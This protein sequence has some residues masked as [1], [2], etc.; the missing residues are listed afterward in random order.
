PLTIVFKDD[1]AEGVENPQA[2]VLLGTTQKGFVQILVVNVAAL[3]ENGTNFDTVFYHEMTH[4]VLND[5]VG[6]EASQRI[7][8]WVQE[9]LAVYICGEGD[10]R[11]HE[12]AQH[13]RRSEVD[14]LVRDVEGPY[15]GLAY[16]QYYLAIKYMVDTAS[17]NAPQALVRNLIQGRT[18]SEAIY[19]S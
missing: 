10:Q 5:A 17:I 1:V 6:G 11:V 4:A 15:S 12:A 14:V 16:P 8:H 18:T 2:Y 19:D 3:A 9:G 7:P 13:F